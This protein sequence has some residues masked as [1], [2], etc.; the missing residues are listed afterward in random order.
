MIRFSR[1]AT[2]NILNVDNDVTDANGLIS[3]AKKIIPS[4]SS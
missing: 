3:K 1:L 4:R 2:V